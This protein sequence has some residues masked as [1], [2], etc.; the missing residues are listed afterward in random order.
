MLATVEV[1]KKIAKL[2]VQQREALLEK[3]RTHRGATFATEKPAR[4]VV[5]EALLSAGATKPPTLVKTVTDDLAVR[6]PEAP[7]VTD[8]AGDPKPDADLRDYENVPLPNV[9]VTFEADPTARLETIEHRTAVEDYIACEVLPYVPDAWHDP[10]KIR[11]GYEVPLTRHFYT[12]TPPRPLT[13]IDA[14][15]EA[16]EAE[17]KDLVVELK[18]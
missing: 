5:Q 15:F 9:R 3:L 7:V 18:G 6:D 13:E 12:Y 8:R 14:E 1:D 16:L 11:I 2:S 10:T 4:Q 17:I